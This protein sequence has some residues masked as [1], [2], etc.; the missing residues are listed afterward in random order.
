MKRFIA[1]L[2]VAIAYAQDAE[3]DADAEEDEGDLAEGIDA[4]G[5]WW[6]SRQE[7]VDD[8]QHES[9]FLFH[10]SQ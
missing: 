9:S 5:D 8:V 6:S 3:T 10:E 2:F 1:A 4:V 7:P